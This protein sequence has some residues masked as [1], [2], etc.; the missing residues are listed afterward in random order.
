[1]PD[2]GPYEDLTAQGA[3]VTVVDSSD[4]AIALGRLGEATYR[5][6]RG[7]GSQSGICVFTFTVADV[8][9]GARVYHVKVGSRVPV[10]YTRDELNSRLTL[11]PG[12]F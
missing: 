4:H 6:V 1:M 12:D 7:N 3:A 11:S 5:D 10:I 2:N 8:P 9:E